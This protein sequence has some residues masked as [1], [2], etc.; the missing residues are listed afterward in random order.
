A[1]LFGFLKREFFEAEQQAQQVPTV[2]LG[3]GL[4]TVQPGASAAPALPPLAPPPAAPPAAEPGPGP[5]TPPA[6][7]QG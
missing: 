4:P 5:Q 6:A 1:G 7:P 3:F 2:D